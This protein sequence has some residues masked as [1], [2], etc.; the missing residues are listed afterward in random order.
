MREGPIDGE[1]DMCMRLMIGAMFVVAIA[2]PRA[3]QTATALDTSAIAQAFGVQGQM[4]GDVYKVTLPRSDL[5]VTVGGV[6]I[7]A[8]LALGSW[9]AFRRAGT[10]AVAHGDL[11]L[12]DREINPV[13]SALQAGRIDITAVHNHLLDETP[14]VEYVHFWG[15][16]RE[17]DLA[18]TLKTALART[19]TPFG[20]PTPAAAAPDFPEAEAILKAL[21]KTGTVRNGVLAVAVPRPEKIMMMG[22]ELP[23][24]MGMAISLNFQKAGDGRVAGTGDFVLTADEVNPVA[25]ALRQHDIS[26][27]ALHNHMLH[28][29]PELY[30]MHFWALGAPDAVGAGLR[31][32]LDATAAKP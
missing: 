3:P 12:L 13:I 6:K 14:H 5:S 10:D 15:R 9:A 25:R 22:V 8:G 29:S 23:P 2:E 31:A 32:A 27:T 4:Q 21:G 1:F 28:G 17:A 16:G 11:V 30:F 19:A 24:S 7:R 18:A 26:V 20:P